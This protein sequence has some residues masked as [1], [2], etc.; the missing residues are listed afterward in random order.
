M[1]VESILVIKKQFVNGVKQKYA[2]A[3]DNCIF[4]R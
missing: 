1:F 3:S 2:G 4:I